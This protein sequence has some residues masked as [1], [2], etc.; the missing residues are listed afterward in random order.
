MQELQNDESFANLDKSQR[1]IITCLANA[2]TSLID[3]VVRESTQTRHCITAQFR[4]VEK[5]YIDDRRYEEIVN[6][7]F[8]PDISSRQEQVDDQFEGVKNSYDWIFDDP[9]THRLEGYDKHSSQRQE[10]QWD[11]FVRWLKS[12]HG[13]Y[14]INGKAGSGKSTLMNHICNHSRRL[15]LLGEWCSNRRLLTPTFFF[16]NA[17]TRLQK[18]IDG[19]LRSLIY[20][21]LKECRELVGC[22]GVS[23][24]ERIS[25]INLMAFT[26]RA[27]AY[28][29]SEPSSSDFA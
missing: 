5:L 26:E 11:D 24:Y 19:L 20:Q 1:H 4:R 15:E 16:W 18:S 23:H 9:R 10:R 17:G 14:W 13:V 29:D 21:M 22:V 12:G 3:L 27:F 7:L 6:S 2:Q 25:L 8:Y 28:L